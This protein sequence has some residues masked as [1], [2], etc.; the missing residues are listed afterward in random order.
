MKKLF[1]I[2]FILFAFTLF[3]NSVDLKPIAKLNGFG[4]EYRFTYP[5]EMTVLRD[6]LFVLD[7]NSKRIIVFDK[8]NLEY[9][10]S[11]SAVDENMINTSKLID[12]SHDNN[13]YLIISD[14]GNNCIHIVS[15]DGTIINV[16]DQLFPWRLASFQDFTYLDLFPGFYQAGIYLF[17]DNELNLKVDMAEYF[18]EN[19][20][21]SV[22]DKYYSWCVT[23]FGYVISLSSRDQLVIFDHN[24]KIIKK[25]AEPI[26]LN[27]PNTLY[28]KPYPHEDGFIVLATSNDHIQSDTTNVEVNYEGILGYYSEKGKLLKTYSLPSIQWLTDAWQKNGNDLY[29]YDSGN[30]IIYRFKLD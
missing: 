20:F 29:L 30:F 3:S 8:E 5:I 26:P 17:E 24:G 25:K 14:Y 12:I 16:I 19:K 6:E 22:L 10:R 7:Q 28:G 13:E 9:K 27:M 21:H 11:F 2:T 4:K 23:D 18:K 1:S 15:A